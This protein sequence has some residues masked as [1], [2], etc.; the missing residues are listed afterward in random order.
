MA[1]DSLVRRVNGQPEFLRW[2]STH[3]RTEKKLWNASAPD[4]KSI[5]VRTG[6]LV[7]RSSRHA[8]SA[9]GCRGDRRILCAKPG[10][11]NNARL[12]LCGAQITG[13]LDLSY[14]RIE[15]PITLR[16]CVF[17]QPIVL[18]KPGSAH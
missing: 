2:Q 13:P 3:K 8:Q 17:D 14:A 11:G 4:G 7:A 1:H 9:G 18:P 12:T 15:H 16:D 6:R 5:L 10:P